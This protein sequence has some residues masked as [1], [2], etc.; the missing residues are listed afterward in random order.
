MKKALLKN[1]FK[2]IKTSYKRF[3]SILLIAL[4]GVGFFAGLRASSPDMVDTI[5]KYYKEQNVY[6]IQIMSTLG[7]TDSDVEAISEIEDVE[8]VYGTYSEDILIKTDNKELVSKVLTVDDVNKPRLIEGNMPANSNECVVEKTFLTS[9]GKNIGDTITLEAND[10]NE[11]IKELNLKI[12]GIVESPLYISRERGTTSLGTGSINNYIYISR[13]NIESEIYTEIYITLKESNKYT[14]GSNRY[15]DYV[16]EVKD[17]I[18]GIKEEREQARY[19][20][21]IGEANEEI[22]KA[23]DEFNTQKADGEKQIAEAETKLQDGKNQL[24]DAENEIKTNETSANKQFA[25]AEKKISNAKVEV[26]ENEDK[27]EEQ[28]QSVTAKLSEAEEQKTE[29]NANLQTIDTT[30]ART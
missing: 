20:E 8:N 15:E 16:E 6:D 13:D 10:E 23:E 22:A 4:L 11:I 30:L 19:D 29:L 5:D 27:L 3:I 14:T 9:T 12:V 25:E 21:L 24:T 26:Q 1:S 7:L 2:E 17:K 28:K 18:E